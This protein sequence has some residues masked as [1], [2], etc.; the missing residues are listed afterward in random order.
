GFSNREILAACRDVT[1][2]AI[3]VRM[4][5]RRPG[6][7]AVLIASSDRIRADLGWRPRRSLTDMVADSWAFTESRAGIR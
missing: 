1:G 5:E 3:P 6:D 4:A 7:P 2:R